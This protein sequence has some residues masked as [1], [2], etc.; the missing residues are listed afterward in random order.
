MPDE[1]WKTGGVTTGF[2]ESMGN[3]RKGRGLEA[4]ALRLNTAGR[5]LGL[6]RRRHAPVGAEYSKLLKKMKIQSIYSSGDVKY[7]AV[8]TV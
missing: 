1:F 6:G 7:S 2:I 5:L 3:Y 8:K 4:F